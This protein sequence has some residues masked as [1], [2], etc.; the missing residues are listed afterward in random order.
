MYFKVLESGVKS[1]HISVTF[2][3]PNCWE[4]ACSCFFNISET[5]ASLSLG[6]STSCSLVMPGFSP[7][8]IAVLLGLVLS[9]LLGLPKNGYCGFIFFLNNS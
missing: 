7:R 3:S 8:S 2:I 6:S 4:Q 5:S 9:C 1:F